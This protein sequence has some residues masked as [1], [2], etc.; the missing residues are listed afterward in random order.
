MKILIIGYGSIGNRYHK[1]LKKY[2][3]EIKVFDI[4]KRAK[5]KDDIFFKSSHDANNWKADIII[6]CNIC[7]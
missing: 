6:I 5:S 7:F 2:S 1:I 4:Q 3:F